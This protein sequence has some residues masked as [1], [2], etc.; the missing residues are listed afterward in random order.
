MKRLPSGCERRGS[1]SVLLDSCF[2]VQKLHALSEERRRF[3][4]FRLGSQAGQEGR[5]SR[6][7][8]QQG[9]QKMDVQRLPFQ[10]LL[11]IFPVAIMLETYSATTVVL[12]NT[13]NSS[14]AMALNYTMDIGSAYFLIARGCWLNFVHKMANISEVQ[15]CEWRAIIRPYNDLK[16]CLEYRADLLNYSFPNTL[17]ENY[18]VSIHRTYFLNCPPEHPLLMDPPENVLLP[19][20][21]TPICLIPFLVTLVVL[22]SK[23]SEM[24][25]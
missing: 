8:W 20:I 13:S 24:K 19:L 18:F 15:W 2:L 3:L 22:K 21:I 17:S 14:D 12:H 16:T 5:G 9:I 11:L 4:L 1:S 7:G 23:D 25:V 10:L 6:A